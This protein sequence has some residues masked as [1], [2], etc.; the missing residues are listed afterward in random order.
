M[1]ADKPVDR[2]VALPVEQ[3][4]LQLPLAGGEH[5]VEA[6]PAREH[7]GSRVGKFIKEILIMINL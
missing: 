4:A 5:G 2:D 6:E 7:H 1:S 3:L